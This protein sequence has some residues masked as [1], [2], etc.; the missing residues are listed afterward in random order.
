[1]YDRPP[2]CD[3]SLQEFEDMAVERLKVLRV[4]EKHN[5]GGSTKFSTEWME[6]IKADLEKQNL[7]GYLDL[8]NL[9]GSNQKMKHYEN[10]RADHISHFI[11]R[12][13]YC[14]SDELRK[15][16]VTH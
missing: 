2:V 6:K 12:L 11:L 7:E 8:A 15:W 4:I 9:L 10:R 16:F 5:M 3:V 1:M 14:R 13:A